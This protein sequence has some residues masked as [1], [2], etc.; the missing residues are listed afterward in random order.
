MSEWVGRKGRVEKVGGWTFVRDGV[1]GWILKLKTWRVEGRV[2]PGNWVLEGKA[3]TVVVRRDVL[4][5][6]G[7]G[8]GGWMGR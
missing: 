8:L 5:F 2:G 7:R 3:G 4:L 6:F 1:E